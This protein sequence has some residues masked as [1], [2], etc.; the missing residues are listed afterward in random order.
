MRSL[1]SGSAASA[2]L[3]ALPALAI[4]LIW[5]AFLGGSFQ[6]DDWNVI[7]NEPRIHSLA[8][9]WESMP[10]IR[11]LLKLSYALNFSFDESPAGFRAFNVLIHALNAT[12]VLWLMHARGLRDLRE[13][14]GFGRLIG[15]GH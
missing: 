2:A 12:L 7:V 11:P 15:P 9:W 14:H 13:E 5:A 1:P 4:V 3:I 8:A 6:F 10:G